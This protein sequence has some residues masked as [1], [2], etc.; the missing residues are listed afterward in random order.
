MLDRWII[1]QADRISP[2]APVP[3]LLEEQQDFSIGG[4]GN[5]AVNIQSI[6]GDVK[7]YGS[8]GQDK[9]GYK[10]LELLGNTNVT[11]YIANDHLITTTKTRLVS[12]NGQ[13]IVRWDR[14]Q[15]YIGEN[16]FNRLFS[17]A[18]INDVICISDYNNCLLYTSP[19]PRD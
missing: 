17:D 14:E 7:L 4:A 10:I 2:E 5:L 12:Q 1:G 11:P 6:N 15:K 3:I 8:I 9:E 19:S 16:A 18:T 13:H